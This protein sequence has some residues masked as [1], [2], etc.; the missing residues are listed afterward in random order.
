MKLINEINES[1]FWDTSQILTHD[2][3]NHTKQK[4]VYFQDKK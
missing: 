4:G 1:L 2:P 3:L